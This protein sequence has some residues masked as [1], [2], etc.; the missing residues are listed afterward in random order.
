MSIHGPKLGTYEEMRKNIMLVYTR[1]PTKQ[2]VCTLHTNKSMFLLH[3]QKRERFL[4]C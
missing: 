2:N 3:I 1:I 4:H